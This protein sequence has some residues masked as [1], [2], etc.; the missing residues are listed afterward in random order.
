MPDLVT[1]QI[2]QDAEKGITATKLNNIVAQSVIQPDF[3]LNKP[4]SSTLDPTDNLLEVKG[5]GTYAR[6]TGSQLIS[7]VSS[8]VDV[9]PQITSVRLRSYNS[10]GNCNFECDQITAGAGVA[11]GA[12]TLLSKACDR[13]VGWKSNASSMQLTFKQVNG[14]IDIPGTSYRIT[15]KVMQISLTTQQASLAATDAAAIIQYVEGPAWR[16]LADD[17][18]S[19][20]IL[21][22]TN[23]A[24]GLKFAV[25]LRDSAAAYSLSKLCTLSSPGV[26]QL[27]QLPNIPKWTASGTFPEAPGQQAYALLIGVAAG[28]SQIPAANDVWGSGVF[29]GAVGMDNFC[30]KPT[31][32]T[33]SIA[34]VQHEPG[35]NCTQLMDLPFDNNL[36]ACKRYFQKS[37]PYANV[38]PTGAD[39]MCL[40][41]IAAPNSATVRC[42]YMFE[43][44]MAKAP[45]MINWDAGTTANNVFVDGIGSVAISGGGGA[46]GR[47]TKGLTSFNLASSQ[48]NTN[49]VAGQIIADTGW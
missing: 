40:G 5:A 15:S 36:W 20:S 1:S 37:G 23:V 8:Q 18:H 28:A 24:G 29:A 3:V 9:T 39:A 7:S 45:T 11:T 43:R 6:I 32:S 22:N 30:S 14:D 38:V 10:V 12:G 25:N 46:I 13:W 49:S 16:E 44:E 47:T 41:R 48:T 42:N 27:I 26:W 35:P 2:F 34:L 4:S 33:L 19:I 31:G 21:A 17:V